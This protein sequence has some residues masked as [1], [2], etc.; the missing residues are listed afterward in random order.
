MRNGVIKKEL[1]FSCNNCLVQTEPLFRQSTKCI[2]YTQPTHTIS[3]VLIVYSNSIISTG[4]RTKF[5]PTKTHCGQGSRNSHKQDRLS[6]FKEKKIFQKTPGFRYTI[7]A[8]IIGIVDNFTPLLQITI[9]VIVN[10]FNYKPALFSSISS[11]KEK[12]SINLC[13]QTTSPLILGLTVR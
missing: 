11:D 8:I 7:K 5:V 10:L 2:F 4:L 13:K 6:I 1:F 3:F 12:P 9:R